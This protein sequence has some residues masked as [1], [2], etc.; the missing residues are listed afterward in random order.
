MS[1]FAT[2]WLP[3][4]FYTVVAFLNIPGV[5][6]RLSG[7]TL[8]VLVA[9]ATLA[10]FVNLFWVKYP[11]FNKLEEVK[12]SYISDTKKYIQNLQKDL[13]ND[14][15]FEVRIVVMKE[16]R[17]LKSEVDPKRDIHFAGRYWPKPNRRHLVSVYSFRGAG[18]KKADDHMRFT[19]SQ[20]VSGQAYSDGEVKYDYLE[21]GDNR[22][23]NLNERQIERVKDVKGLISHPIIRYEND[24]GKEEKVVGVINVDSKNDDSWLMVVDDDVRDYVVN[25]VRE[26]AAK[27]SPII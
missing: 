4:I 9:V 19:L 22:D 13:S 18:E 27:I 5:R 6:E 14:L 12:K 24:F 16:K 11:S 26:T 23:Y 25:R 10:F 20:G 3:V 21:E 7:I 15:T 8:F 1:R 2:L 17:C